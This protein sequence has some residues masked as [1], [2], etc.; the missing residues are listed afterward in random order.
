MTFVGG[1]KQR[2]LVVSWFRPRE[3]A[4]VPFGSKFIRE[5]LVGESAQP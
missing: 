4:C 3:V 5:A 2:G 1:S